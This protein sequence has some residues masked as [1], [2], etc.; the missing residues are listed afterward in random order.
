MTFSRLLMTE[1]MVEFQSIEH[2]P[3]LRTLSSA[4][5]GKQRREMRAEDWMGQKL[6]KTLTKFIEV[7]VRE[8]L[9]EV[10]AGFKSTN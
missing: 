10:V 9:A 1:M 3:S 2:D 5:G 8:S 4:G 7:S 6:E